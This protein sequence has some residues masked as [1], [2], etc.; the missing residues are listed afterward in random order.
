MVRRRRRTTRPPSN[1]ACRG[2]ALRGLRVLD[3][4]L[5]GVNGFFLVAAPETRFLTGDKISVKTGVLVVNLFLDV[6]LRL[7][8]R[9]GVLAQQ[10]VDFVTATV[11]IAA[12]QRFIDQRG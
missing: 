3:V 5:D 12:Q 4:E 10:F 7:E 8:A 6:W 9:F 1:S 11:G 2:E